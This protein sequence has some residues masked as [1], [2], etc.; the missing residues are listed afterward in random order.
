[1]GVVVLAGA[2]WLRDTVVGVS[3]V[4]LCA[5][6]H[7]ADELKGLEWRNALNP[8][9]AAL[10][11][12]T[13]SCSRCPALPAKPLC[14]ALESHKP[15]SAQSKGRRSQPCT[16]HCRLVPARDGMCTSG[17]SLS[18][19]AQ[20]RE[21][22]EQLRRLVD[23]QQPWRTQGVACAHIDRVATWHLASSTSTGWPAAA[24]DTP[25]GLLDKQRRFA[26]TRCAVVWS[27]SRHTGPALLCTATLHNPLLSLA[28][29]VE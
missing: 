3:L 26:H 10:K 11:M 18:R 12:H 17:T 16:T 2:A 25:M 24:H 22:V 28:G 4:S 13:D 27:G 7:V 5:V 20:P 19:R 15:T 14:S 8:G 21:L 1:M 23:L 9:R 6:L 29:T